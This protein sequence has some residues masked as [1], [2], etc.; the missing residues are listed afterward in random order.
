PAA[1][2]AP[3]PA[4]PSPAPAD[5]DATHPGM[6]PSPMV[7]VVYLSPEPGAP[8]YV[9]V[10]AR[11]AQ[12]QTLL[13]IEAMKTFNQIKAPRAG[14]VTKILVESGTPVEYGEPLLIIE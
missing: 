2:P 11:V 6:V 12:G 3:A 7:G 8:P 10:G 5:S 13:L 14:V 4:A 9:T 1:S